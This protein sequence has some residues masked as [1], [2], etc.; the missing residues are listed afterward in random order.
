MSHRAT[1]F[2][3]LALLGGS[4]T[5]CGYAVEQRGN[6]PPDTLVAQIQPGTTDK[7]TVTQLL[8][9]PSSVAAFDDS[10]WYYISQKSQAIAFFKPETLDQKVLAI[11]FDQKG[12]VRDVKKVGME[13]RNE[14]QPV[15]RTTPAPGKELTFFEQLIGNFGRFNSQNHGPGGTTP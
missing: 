12:V 8:G 15:E 10:T 14:L 4:L 9:S 2:L 11:S 6:A 7:Q 3:A 1:A 13:A 5:A